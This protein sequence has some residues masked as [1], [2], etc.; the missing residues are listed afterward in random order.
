MKFFKYIFLSLITLLSI[1]SF[2]QTAMPASGTNVGASSGSWLVPA[3]VY[4]IEIDAWGG[5]G[6]GAG[7]STSGTGGLAGGAGGSRSTTTISVTPGQIIYF[8]VAASR[9][10]TT[11]NAANGND[12]WVNKSLNSAPTSSTDGVVAKGGASAVGTAAG[13]GSTTGCI[14]TSNQGGSG[15][16]GG[17]TAGGGGS[18]AGTNLDG[19]DA[20]GTAGATAPAGGGNGGNGHSSGGAGSAGS[21][22]GGGGGGAYK[23]NNTS[24][25]GG[26]GAAGRVIL[27]YLAIPNCA[28]LN[29]P[30]NNSTG[31]STNQV[32]SWAAVSGATSYD[33]YF[34]TSS[35]PPFVINQTGTSYTPTLSYST[36]YYWK[37]VAKNSAG[38]ALSCSTWNF[39]TKDPGCL[40]ATYGQYPSTTYTPSC[41]GTVENITTTGYA[42]EYSVVSLQNGETYTF[43]SSNSTDFITISN[44]AG[45]TVLAYGTTPVSW[46]SNLTGNVRFYTHTNE[47]CGSSTTGRTRRV[48]CSI[49][50]LCTSLISPSDGSTGQS[51]GT[52]LSWQSVSNANSYDVYFGTSSNPPFIQNQT[53]TTYSPSLSYNTTYYWKIVP[54]SSVGSATGCSVWSFTTGGPGCLNST[55]GQ[56]P[57]SVYNPGCTGTPENITTAGY[58]GEYSMVTLIS[59]VNYTFSS[60]VATDFITISDELGTTILAYGTGSVS[61]TCLTDG[62][63]RFYTH[64]DNACGSSSTSRVRRIQCST[65]PPP[66]NDLIANAQDVGLC[67][68]SFNGNTKFATNSGDGPSCWTAPSEN[69]TAPGV[70]YTV[71]GNGQN[72]TAS[73]CG[74]N[75]DTKLF[76]YTGTPGSLT[77]LTYNDDFCSTQSQVTFSSTLNT[78]YYM[79]VTGYGS[80]KGAFTFSVS[81]DPSVPVISTN[82]TNSTICPGS[83]WTFSVIASGNQGPLSYQWYLDGN[84]ISGATQS[85]YDASTAG[86]YYVIVSNS[87]GATTQSSNATLSLFTLPTITVNSPEICFGNS[88][89][90]IAS[91]GTSYSWSTGATT[92]SI[93]VS[94]ISTTNYIVTGTD[95]NGCQ[96][97]ATSTVTVNPNPLVSLNT[98]SSTICSGGSGTNNITATPSSGNPTYNYQWQYFN[99]TSWVNTGTNVNTLN[100]TPSATREYRVVINDSKSCLVTSSSHTVTVVPDPINPTLNTKSPNQNDICVGTGVSATF[101]SGSDGVGCQD[102]FQYSI[103][104]GISWSSYNPGNTISTSGLTQGTTV[105]IRGRRGNCSTGIGC[106]NNAYDVLVQWT[107][108][109]PPILST[110]VSDVSCNGGN[111]GNINLTVSGSVGPFSF[112]WSGPNG[113]TS[114]L[115]DLSNVEAGS[116]TVVVSTP[117]G[118]QST[119]SITVSQPSNM[120]LTIVGQN[121]AC[122]GGSSGNIDLTVSGGTPTYTYSWSNGETTEDISNLSPGSYT[123]NVSDANGC[124]ATSTVS[125]SEPSLPISLSNTNQNVLCNGGSDGSIDLNVS[126]GT[127]GYTYSWSNGQTSEDISGL[128]AGTYSVLVTDF[129][130]CT[131]TLTTTILQPS[132]L[133]SSVAVYNVN[134]Y[135]QNT[136]SIN[137]TVSGG[138][139]GYTYLWSNGQTSAY[140]TALGAGTYSVL[141]TDVNGC[142]STNNATITQPTL[143]V[144]SHTKVNLT[145]YNSNDGSITVTA[146]GGTPP[147]TYGWTNGMTGSTISNLPAGN[148]TSYVSDSKGC[149]KL[150]TINV[151]QPSVLSS[152]VN[153]PTISTCQTT[154]VVITASVIGGTAPYT[155]LWSTGATTN[156]ISVLPTQTTSYTIQITDSKG[157][158][159]NNIATVTV[160]QTVGLP[161]VGSVSG[162]TQAYN[163]MLNGS[164]ATYSVN[165]VPGATSYIWY[166][167]NNGVWVI[168]NNTSNILTV[169]FQSYFTGGDFYVAALDGCSI[170]YSDTLNVSILDNPIIAGSSCGIPSGSIKTYYV[171]NSIPGLTYN[172]TPPYGSVILSGQGNDTVQIKYSSYFQSQSQLYVN[173]STIYG[174]FTGEKEILRNASSPT[175]ILGPQSICADGTTIYE[176][177]VDS[178]ATA[179]SYIWGVPN[180]VSIV[181]GQSNDTIQVRFSTSYIGG[182]F[183]VMSVNQC[184]SSPMRYGTVS[185]SNQQF[186]PGTIS[187][188]GDLCP[189]LG[190]TVTYS[191]PLSAGYTY[192]WLAPSGMT[193]LSGQGTNIITLQV[194][195]SF[196]SGTLSVKLNEGCGDS[197]YST[198]SLSTQQT[199]ISVSQIQGLT[200]PCSIVGTGQ[201][202][203]YSIT[204]IS[205]VN[206]NWSVP[207]NATIVSGQGSNVISVSFQ[208]GFSGGVISVLVSGGCASPITVSKTLSLGYPSMTIQGTRCVEN[209][210]SYNYSVSFPSMAYYYNVQSYTWVPP[211]NAVVSSGQGTQSATITYPSN[212]ESNCTNNMCDSIKVYVQFPCGVKL[213]KMKI[214]M[215]TY[216]ASSIIGPPSTCGPDTVMLNVAVPTPVRATGYIW[217]YPNGAQFLNLNGG[218]SS[219]DTIFAKINSTYFGGSF[220]VMS[221]NQCGSTPMRYFTL[222]KVCPTAIIINNDPEISTDIITTMND[223]LSDP[224]YLENQKRPLDFI[225]Y[226]NPGQNIINLRIFKGNSPYYLIQITNLIGQNV[227]AKLH[228]AE[229]VIDISKFEE[230]VFFISIQDNEGNKLTKQLV[231]ER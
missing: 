47:A 117:S 39:T 86:T 197:P 69:W 188:P 173:T 35:T 79:L 6:A 106:S 129:N 7:K 167:P 25:S 65:P 228:E 99:G 1:N 131:S 94:P 134:C 178:V 87:C 136:G 200:N 30:S 155:Y 89:T 213:V 56:Y 158:V 48:Q 105:Q 137:L 104:S 13:V 95:V 23:N 203:T 176:Y 45:T 182:N 223:I 163:Y 149:T 177:Y 148:Y 168:G 127:P 184:G 152:S 199:N 210:W 92:S 116:Y 62:N 157:C 57:T 142:Q 32:L 93:S 143:L 205:G 59:N 120:V 209:G 196:T 153:S 96:N 195:N 52:Q 103:N 102:I 224:E 171:S 10:G 29:A 19:N 74:S 162:P 28:S 31:I 111:N 54:K 123:V 118:C 175:A 16:V 208:S 125:I 169:Q 220:S 133:S 67:G 161:I 55:Y 174:V 216:A 37:V 191:V 201:T 144:A 66:A 206:Y 135:G 9:P 50:P 159:N 101:N 49:P 75:Y 2:S 166:I 218:G 22:P 100:A 41:M 154:P 192:T 110:N 71:V 12:T 160:S 231:I 172:W 146:S 108:V 122:N 61:F 139:P 113:F 21:I 138:T 3:N 107:I 156:T 76:I 190:T 5:G 179:T 215:T 207:V 183:S 147:Y 150:Q 151:S 11:G 78:T 58:A 186:Y 63:Y 42:S 219:N 198:R 187:G 165:P 8:R 193:I 121:V 109:T 53:G 124:I 164:S 88:T 170:S 14:G 128:I 225:T 85:T 185:N 17:V 40:S 64:T 4:S 77:C 212:F 80:A 119:T 24:R 145:C 130:G 112:N 83:S 189:Y 126:G 72:I 204:P 90:I 181:S 202:T 222:P 15:R 98:L 226:P 114:T 60:S 229:D 221:F 18:G 20:T 115:E 84:V 132:A 36:Q 140:A 38:D 91:G 194:S 68:G 211:A 51:I 81:L 70:W 180:G 44:S 33:V 141:I 27:T 230:G 46:T 217:G 43:S 214:G 82:P 227:Y 97:T 26:A 34:G 73:L